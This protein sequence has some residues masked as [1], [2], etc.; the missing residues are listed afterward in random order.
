MKHVLHQINVSEKA[1]PP[2]YEEILEGT[3]NLLERLLQDLNDSL[4]AS[5]D[6]AVNN[7]RRNEEAMTIKLIES[8]E[9]LLSNQSESISQLQRGT[10]NE[11][12]FN[13][14][15]IKMMIEAMVNIQQ[16]QSEA[17]TRM[18]EQNVMMI[19]TMIDT[20]NNQSKSITQ[21]QKDAN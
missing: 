3:V 12:Q 5:V 10:S 16:N 15:R 18:Q 1:E 8:V 11:R 20:Q 19:K 2:K 4:S 21:M 7:L 14:A 9:K 6:V 13:D 17:L